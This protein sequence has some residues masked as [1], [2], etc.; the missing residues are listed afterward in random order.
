MHADRDAAFPLQVHAV[1]G[2]G[3]V[4]S[5][6]HRPGSQEELVGKRALSVIDMSDDAKIAYELRF[7]HG[8][9]G[10]T[11]QFDAVGSDRRCPLIPSYQTTAVLN[12]SGVVIV[13]SMMWGIAEDAS[14]VQSSTTNRDVQRWEPTGEPPD[15][16]RQLLD[17]QGTGVVSPISD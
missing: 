15:F 3:A 16:S 1:E 9:S 5:A 14:T 4:V 8:S 12:R 7:G 10:V 13:P 17:W 2:L 11:V 6:R